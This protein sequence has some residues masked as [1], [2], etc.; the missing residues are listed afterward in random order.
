[1][2]LDGKNADARPVKLTEACWPIEMYIQ[3]SLRL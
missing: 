2:T 1:M 3:A